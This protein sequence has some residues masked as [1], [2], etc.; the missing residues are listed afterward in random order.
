MA[1]NFD[2]IKWLV[3]NG[4]LVAIFFL[5]VYAFFKIKDQIAYKITVTSEK[6]DIAKEG[7]DAFKTTV[8]DGL[9]NV[10]KSLTGVGEKVDSMAM[11]QE[12]I[13]EELTK[14]HD[15]VGGLQTDMDNV[16]KKLKE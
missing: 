10:A 1:E 5:C 11:E 3:N 9:D 15:K 4:V 2:A 14:V 16:K 6:S 7:A 12:V 13:K 8:K